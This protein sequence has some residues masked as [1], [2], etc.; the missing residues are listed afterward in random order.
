MGFTSSTTLLFDKNG[1][2]I[3]DTTNYVITD[4]SNY[5]ISLAT[6]DTITVQ[7]QSSLKTRNGSYRIVGSLV[8]GDSIVLSVAH[9]GSERTVDTTLAEILSITKPAIGTAIVQPTVLSPA[10]GGL[11][12]IQI[13]YI[14]V[15]LRATNGTYL[16]SVINTFIGV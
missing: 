5:V 4:G 16:F 8:E 3:P 13:P 1:K 11:S 7:D 2:P 12:T 14:G 6:G 9:A 10:N 15:L